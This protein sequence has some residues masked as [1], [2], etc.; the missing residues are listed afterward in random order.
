MEITLTAQVGGSD[1]GNICNPLIVSLRKS[2]KLIQNDYSSGLD[3]FKLQMRISGEVSEYKEETGVH[4]IR[5]MKKNNYILGELVFGKE[6][7]E[8]KTSIEIIL[9]FCDYTE[10]LF[11]SI[12][13]KLKNS[14]I[15]IEEEKLIFDL[16][17]IALKKF[18]K[19]N[20]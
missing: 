11:I 14:K 19:D 7:W 6:I 20:L 3:K 2:L 15:Q 13:D 4:N 1:V 8:N 9:A 5:L 12:I 16:R 18:K 17:N 10:K